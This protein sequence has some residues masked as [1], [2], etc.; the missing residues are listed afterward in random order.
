MGLSS[1]EYA[2]NLATAIA[3][4]QEKWKSMNGE[5]SARWTEI[6]LQRYLFNYSEVAVE[7]LRDITKADVLAFFDRHLLVNAP[8]RC[9]MSLQI[10][11]QIP[12]EQKEKTKESDDRQQEQIFTAAPTE[13]KPVTTISVGELPRFKA[14]LPLYPNMYSNVNRSNM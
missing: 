2:T 11:S 7:L 4:K 14:H 10:A 13:R 6:V 1:D 3:K 8:T 12:E 5:G 9:K